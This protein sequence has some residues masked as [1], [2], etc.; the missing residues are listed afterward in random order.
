MSD[1]GAH[2]LAN[3]IAEFR[4]LKKHEAEI[5]RRLATTARAVALVAGRIVDTLRSRGRRRGAKRTRS[6]LGHVPGRSREGAGL[7]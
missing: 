1:L 4:L 2:Y 7:A 3:T 6:R 5:R